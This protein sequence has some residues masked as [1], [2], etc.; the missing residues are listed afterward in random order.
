MNDPFIKLT[1]LF[2]DRGHKSSPLFLRPE[3]VVEIEDH[4]VHVE[5]G[6]FDVSEKA[7]QIRALVV[8]KLAENRQAETLGK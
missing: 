1:K 3:R 6:S 8:A 5:G 2:T 7:E 4:R